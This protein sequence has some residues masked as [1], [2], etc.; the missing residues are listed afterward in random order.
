M[1]GCARIRRTLFEM[2]VKVW[3]YSGL[4]TF[5]CFIAYYI[6]GGLVTFVLLI[7]SAAGKLC[8]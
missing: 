1:G 7:I 3:A 2:A 4:L 8:L 5:L 6:Y